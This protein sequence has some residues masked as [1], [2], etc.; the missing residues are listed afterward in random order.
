MIKFV[1]KSMKA[2]NRVRD[3]LRVMA[4]EQYKID[5]Q[6]SKDSAFDG[7]EAFKQEWNSHD[8]HSMSYEEVLA[9]VAELEYSEEEILEIRSAYYERKS[10]FNKAEANGTSS[11][12]DSN[13]YSNG[14]APDDAFGQFAS[15]L[16]GSGEKIYREE[17]IAF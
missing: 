9:F 10:R 12:G 14:R 8:V 16:S 2:A 13:G 4:W 15:Q 11:N 5:N 1:T 7:Y 6:L 17:D 3:G